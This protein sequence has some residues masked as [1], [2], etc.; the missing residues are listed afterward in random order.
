MNANIIEALSKLDV[1]NDNHW[2]EQGLPR[3]ETVKFLTGD[4][5]ITRDAIN[6]AF[7]GFNRNNVSLTPAVKVP[8]IETPVEVQEISVV[9]EDDSAIEPTLLDRFESEQIYL[10]VLIQ[11]R[12]KLTKDVVEQTYKVHGLATEIQKISIEKTSQEAIQSYLQSQQ[13]VLQER[14]ARIRMIADSGIKLKELAEGLK[15]PLDVALSRKK[16]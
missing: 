5:S 2:T 12:D 3:I 8:V 10:E 7:P 6:A 11:E 4:T 14:G 9:I 13:G 1:S 16:A 15:S